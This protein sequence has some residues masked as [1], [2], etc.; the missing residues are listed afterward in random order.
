M[1]PRIVLDVM[2]ADLGPAPAVEGAIQAVKRLEVEVLLVGRQEE[3]NEALSG[4]GESDGLTVIDA[5]EVIDMDNNPTESVRA[6]PDASMNVGMQLLKDGEADAFVTA[7]NTGAAMTAALLKLGRI[8]GISR[9]ALATVF[10]AP[11]KGRT[12]I[13]DVGAN[14]D[15]RPIHLIQFAHMGAAYM[16]RMHDVTSP[17]VGLVSNGQED[18][19]GNALTLEVHAALRDGNLNFTGNVEGNDLMNHVVDVAVVDGFTGNVLMKTAEGIG[20]MIYSEVERAVR[21]KPW[22][23]LAGLVLK[24]E[25]RKTKRRLDHTETGGAQLLGTKGNVII[26]HGASNA[27]STFNSIRSARNDVRGGLMEVMKQVAR[28]VPARKPKPRPKKRVASK[29]L[30][31]AN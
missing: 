1:K 5:R 20:E 25:L 13:L 9:P 23:M 16:E 3:I 2:G 14:A 7:G 11:G 15:C 19:K 10:P 24:P 22:T 6:K 18:I 4:A 29:S 21:Q 31:A 30:E 17:R 28:D 12:I 27:G 26:G 8:R